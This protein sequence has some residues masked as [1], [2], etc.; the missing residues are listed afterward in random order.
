MPFIFL[1][2][3]LGLPLIEISVFI[4][5]GSE[6]GG[7]LTLL[8]TIGTAA[9][10]IFIVRL[11]GLQIMAEMKQSIALDSPPMEGL[12]HGFFLFFAGLF[13]LIPGFIT[14]FMGALLLVP[15]LRLYLGRTGL[16]TMIL[17][18]NK[19]PQNKS[20]GDN[21]IIE[22]QYEKTESDDKV[23]KT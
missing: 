1:L 20:H 9:L 13:L 5:V 11:Q 2:V 17:N 18:K 19:Q 22:G 15:A 16:A 12:V 23:K 4:E 3:L 6:I 14:D 21:I 8:L 10:G 7:L